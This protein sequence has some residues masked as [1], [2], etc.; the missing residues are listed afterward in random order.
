MAVLFTFAIIDELFRLAFRNLTA[1]RNLGSYIFRWGT[2]IL[3]L[4]ACVDT[5][6]FSS[7]TRMVGFSGLILTG[8]RA[9]RAMLCLLAFLL[10]LGARHLRIPVR[11][12]LFGI[13]LGF[14]IYMFSKVFLDTIAMQHLRSPNFINRISGAVY[15]T[16]CLLWLFYAKYGEPLPQAEGSLQSGTAPSLIDAINAMVEQSMHRAGKPL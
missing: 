14:L 9:A 16:S 8:D 13:T 7:S 11:S 10:L 12:T 1:V 2:M 3:L 6:S 5:L 15:L 4:A